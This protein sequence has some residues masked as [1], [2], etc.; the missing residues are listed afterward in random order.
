MTAPPFK[1]T[2]AL[3]ATAVLAGAL[4]YIGGT[5][6]LRSAVST[7]FGLSFAQSASDAAQDVRTLRAIRQGDTASATSMLEDRLDTNLLYLSSYET[8]V[9][10]E[11]RRSIVYH[12][13]DAVRAYRSEVP[14]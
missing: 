9:P 5:L 12:N 1:F 4:G 8:T 2:L 11:F 14:S 6:R 3:A 7:L 10:N 13:L